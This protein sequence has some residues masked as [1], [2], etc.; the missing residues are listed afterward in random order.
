MKTLMNQMQ[1][2]MRETQEIEEWRNENRPTAQEM[3]IEEIILPF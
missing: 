3:I 1:N 2:M